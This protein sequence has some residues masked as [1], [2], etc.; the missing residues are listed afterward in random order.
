YF[1]DGLTEELI[2]SVAKIGSLRVISRQSVM[3][4]R[5]ST[6]LLPEIAREIGVDHVLEGSVLRAGNR[7]R[8]SL[9]LIRADP[10]EHLWAERYDRSLE[11]VLGVQAEVARAV[12]AEIEI[13]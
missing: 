1:V 9:Q 10:E 3:R 11:D 13:K 5:G 7:V 6:K 4:Y 12:A 8:I 2:T